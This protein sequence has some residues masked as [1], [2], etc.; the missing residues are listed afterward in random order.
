MAKRHAQAMVVGIT[1]IA[2]MGAAVV[3]GLFGSAS[4][5]RDTGPAEAAGPDHVIVGGVKRKARREKRTGPF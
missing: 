2:L 3:F 1:M 4:G 5:Q